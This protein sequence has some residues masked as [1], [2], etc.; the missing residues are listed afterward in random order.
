MIYSQKDAK[1][2]GSRAR[3]F[4]IATDVLAKSILENTKASCYSAVVN[5]LQNCTLWTTVSSFSILMLP[6]VLSITKL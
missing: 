6:H 3:K 4:R 2:V 1:A 5:F